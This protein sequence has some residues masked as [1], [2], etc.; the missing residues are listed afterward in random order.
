MSHS[1]ALHDD[2]T[3]LSPALTWRPSHNGHNALATRE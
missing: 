2:G 3:S 1:Q